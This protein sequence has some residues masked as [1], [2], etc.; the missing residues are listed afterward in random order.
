MGARKFLGEGSCQTEAE[1]N[2]AEA[3]EK[4]GAPPLRH[5][6]LGVPPLPLQSPAL[7]C[8]PALRPGLAPPPPSEYP[9]ALRG[10]EIPDA[11]LGLC[12]KEAG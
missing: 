4:Q 5:S 11:R 6:G 2:E 1:G 8:L 3:A 9:L 7:P 10:E 12:L